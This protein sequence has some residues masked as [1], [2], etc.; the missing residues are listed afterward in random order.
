MKM[1]CGTPIWIYYLFLVTLRKIIIS[2]RVVPPRRREC[3]FPDFQIFEMFIYIC[4]PLSGAS[5]RRSVYSLGCDFWR[6]TSFPRGIHSRQVRII[7]SLSQS[8]RC[9]LRDLRAAQ[10]SRNTNTDSSIK[11][12][13]S[14]SRSKTAPRR[15]QEASRRL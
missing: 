4:L 12:S 15:L 13:N 3:R 14:S 7:T 9:N 10:S 8:T 11:R 5:W 2:N 1:S 6:R